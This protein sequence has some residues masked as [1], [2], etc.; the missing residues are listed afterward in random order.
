MAVSP[1]SPGWRWRWPPGGAGN[2]S[3]NLV[4]L[5]LFTSSGGARLTAMNA[6]HFTVVVLLVLGTTAFV[7]GAPGPSTVADAVM[8]GD[9]TAVRKLILARADVNAPQVDG[10][11]ALHWA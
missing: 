5:T 4:Y 6:R 11:T 1:T 3:E 8:N 10:A 2:Y 7:A 9:T